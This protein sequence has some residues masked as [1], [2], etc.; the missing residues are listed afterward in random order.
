M[1][2]KYDISEHLEETLKVIYKKD[3]NYIVGLHASGLAAAVLATF[4]LSMG[5]DN[6]I[7]RMIIPVAFLFIILTNLTTTVML[8]VTEHNNKKADLST[9]KKTTN[10]KK[11]ELDLLKDKIKWSY[12]IRSKTLF[13]IVIGYFSKYS[14]NLI[15]SIFFLI[16]KITS[17]EIFSL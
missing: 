2:Y 10:S 15:R 8:F 13:L 17:L 11:T 3:K 9:I 14:F 4:P 6:D 7:T 5:I 1:S 16:S 12:L